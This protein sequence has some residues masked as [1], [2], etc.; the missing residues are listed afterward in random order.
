MT[1]A[2]REQIKGFAAK[3]FDGHVLAVVRQ[4]KDGKAY[5]WKVRNPE[6]EKWSYWFFVAELPGAIVQYGDVGGVLIEAG[7]G[8]DIGW[9]NGA[10][11]SLDYV[12]EKS[13]HRRDHF[14]EEKFKAFLIEHGHTPDEFEGYED[15]VLETGDSDAYESC[16][17][18]PSEALWGYWALNTFINLYRATAPKESP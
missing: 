17:D 7:A 13:K 14:V 11:G 2:Y 9:L 8:Y 18:W 12:L 10:I 1:N 16:H 5:V 4:D 6:P 3:A 15:F